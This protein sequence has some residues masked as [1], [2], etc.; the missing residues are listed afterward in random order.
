MGNA[1]SVLQRSI[2]YT[3]KQSFPQIT[4]VQETF[5]PIT[6]QGV[7]YMTSIIPFTF[8]ATSNNQTVFTLPVTPT[9]MVCLF[10]MGTGQNILGGDYSINGNVITLGSNAPKLLIGDTV[11]GAYQL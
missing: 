10:I 9:S 4:V 6:V 3:L 7:S 5:P 1:I 11:Y 8:T 2:S